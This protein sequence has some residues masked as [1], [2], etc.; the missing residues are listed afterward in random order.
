LVAATVGA[1]AGGCVGAG[2]GVAVGAGAHATAISTNAIAN[3]AILKYFIVCIFIF[4]LLE[5]FCIL[6]FS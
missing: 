6:E 5:S 1:A 2:T 4:L 3:S